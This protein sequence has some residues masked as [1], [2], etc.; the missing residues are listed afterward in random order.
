M[1]KYIYKICYMKDW[2]KAKKMGSF[3]GVG[4]DLRDNYIHF[5]TANQLEKTLITH[6]KGVKNL[7]L[8]EVNYNDVNIKWEKSRDGQKFPHL[9]DTF[10]INKVRRVIKIKLNMN[11][12]HDIVLKD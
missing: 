4:I 8:L 2:N 11:N 1:H 6:F 12:K 9:Y 10:S 3:K 5:C 7:C